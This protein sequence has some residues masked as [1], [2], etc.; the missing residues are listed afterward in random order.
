M[1]ETAAKAVLAKKNGVMAGLKRIST[2]PYKVEPILIPIEEVMLKES[3][4]PLEY[5]INGNDIS[6]EYANWLRPLVNEN[7]TFVSFIDKK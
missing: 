2:N 1:G 7:K 6:E 3:T 5:I 4:F